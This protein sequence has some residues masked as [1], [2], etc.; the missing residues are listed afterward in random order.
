MESEM[1]GHEKGAFTGAVATKPGLIEASSGG[2]AFLD[3]IGELP[4]PQQGK[5]LRVREGG[6]VMRVG[7]LKPRSIDVRSR[8]PPI[9]ALPADGERGTFPRDPYLRLN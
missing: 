6:E 4:L 1:F 2:T 3:E 9:R 5:P 8:P 7:A